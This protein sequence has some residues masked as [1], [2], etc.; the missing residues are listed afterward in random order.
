LSQ[1]RELNDQAV[2]DVEC[3]GTNDPGLEKAQP[4]QLCFIAFLP[5]ILDSKAEGRNAYIDALKGLAADYKD[6]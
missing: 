5:D 4:A 1:V 3:L 2:M 6:R